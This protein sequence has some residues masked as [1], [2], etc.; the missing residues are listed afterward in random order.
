MSVISNQ[1]TK[2][3]ASKKRVHY[4][5]KGQIKRFQPQQPF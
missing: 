1:P 5:D 4:T 3:P 2:K